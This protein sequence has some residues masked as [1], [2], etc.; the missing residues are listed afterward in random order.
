MRSTQRKHAHTFEIHGI[1]R[2]IQRSKHQQHGRPPSDVQLRQ[3]VRP[4][5]LGLRLHRVVDAEGMLFAGPEGL[6]QR[7]RSLS[8]L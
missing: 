7:N 5:Q 4:R 2:I 8:T 1:Q 3:R 6:T